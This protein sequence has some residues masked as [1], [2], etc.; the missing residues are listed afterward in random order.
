MNI[1][2]I[3]IRPSEILQ[4]SDQYKDALNMEVDMD[5]ADGISDSDVVSQDEERVPAWLEKVT[6]WLESLSNCDTTN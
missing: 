3:L 4:E 5:E 1:K 6:A 2:F